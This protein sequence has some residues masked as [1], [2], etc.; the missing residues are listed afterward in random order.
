MEKATSFVQQQRKL[1]HKLMERHLTEPVI[2]IEARDYCINPSNCKG[3]CSKEHA[4]IYCNVDLRRRGGAPSQPCN[5]SA[6]KELIL[7]RDEFF[8]LMA[9]MEPTRDLLLLPNPTNDSHGW[10]RHYSN[11]SLCCMPFFWETVVDVCKGLAMTAKVKEEAVISKVAFNFGNWETALSRDPRALDCHGHAHLD[12]ELQAALALKET[13]PVLI[14]RTNAPNN[15]IEENCSALESKR[16]LAQN[17][18]LLRQDMQLLLQGMKDNQM[19]K[20]NKKKKNKNKQEHQMP[21]D[22]KALKWTPMKISR[23]WIQVCMYCS[24][25]QWNTF[26]SLGSLS[27]CGFLRLLS[28][29][30]SV[31]IGADSVIGGSF[32]AFVGTLADSTGLLPLEEG[33]LTSPFWTLTTACKDFNSGITFKWMSAACLIQQSGIYRC[34]IFVFY[35]CMSFVVKD[36][37]VTCNNTNTPLALKIVFA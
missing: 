31:A 16:L 10:K 37:R 32:P 4:K 1:A 5:W 11:T 19:K 34:I 3:N 29:G 28:F 23:I 22:T 20:K 14:G 6:A 35:R 21:V 18:Q 25:I 7:E 30:G 9:R 15:Y 8:V 2:E 33:L 36:L 27:V 24:I 26:Y 13:Y 12:L 17:L